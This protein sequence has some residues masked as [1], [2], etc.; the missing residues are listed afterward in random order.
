M[1][2]NF[3]IGKLFLLYNLMI[4]ILHY[5]VPLGVD[6]SIQILCPSQQ[7]APFSLQKTTLNL[8][9]H[10]NQFAILLSMSDSSSTSGER[11]SPLSDQS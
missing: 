6:F 1:L 7:M 11:Y 4:L 5:I 3:M 8:V 10:M 2:P 9:F